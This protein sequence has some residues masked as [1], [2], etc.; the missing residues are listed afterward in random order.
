MPEHD[1]NVAL[2]PNGVA[3]SGEFVAAD[4]VK[5]VRCEAE[6]ATSFHAGFIVAGPRCVPLVVAMDRR[7]DPRRVG[8]GKR[9][10]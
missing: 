7:V 1:V 9:R 3:Q 5:R 6:R 4:G 2:L 8:F 10:C